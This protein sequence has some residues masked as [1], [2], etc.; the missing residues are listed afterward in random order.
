MLF[1]DRLKQCREQVGLTQEEIAEK[2]HLTRQA[3]SKWETGN[4]RA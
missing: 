4:Q 2:L 1:N 3:V